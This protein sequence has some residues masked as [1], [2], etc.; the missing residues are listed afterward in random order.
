LG[1][2]AVRA[3]PAEALLVH[4]LIVIDRR[5]TGV[6]D[7]YSSDDLPVLEDLVD[8]LEAVLDG[9]EYVELAG[10][11]HFPWAGDQDSLI[12]EV[13]RFVGTVRSDI[14]DTFDRVL[15][16]ILFTDIVDSTAHAAAMG[17]SPLA[18]YFASSTS[19]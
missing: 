12:A 9:A 13:E 8:D 7:R 4:A 1:E 19:V 11:D 17:R 15:A 18:S 6:S 10:A 3:L 16:T 2:P 14:Q 5:G